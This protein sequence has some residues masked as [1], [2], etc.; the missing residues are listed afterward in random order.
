MRATRQQRKQRQ[1]ASHGASQG[2]AKAGDILIEA[3][4]RWNVP[5]WVLVGVK[6]LE[7]GT[8]TGGGQVSSAGALGPFQFEPGTAASAGVK[9][10][11]NFYESADGA[12]KLLAGYKQ[13]FGSWNAA[14]EAYN[15]GEGA[16]GGGYAYTEADAKKKLRE[17]GL[18]GLAGRATK[19][20]AFDP[21]SIFEEGL[22]YASPLYRLFKGEAPLPKFP[23]EDL[24]PGGLGS[25]GKSAIEPGS[26]GISFP[27][28]EAFFEL[29][30]S[31]QLWIRLAEI[32]GGAILAYLALKELTGQGISDLPGAKAAQMAA[33]L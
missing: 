27:N 16:V 10:P 18:G 22:K 29:L 11:N 32:I 25:G 30:R 21:G 2:S 14:L 17:Y 3:S 23:G 6:L 19:N 7:T 28:I 4:R 26:L 9:D 8:D 33:K 15:G 13:K 1:G 20:V 12:A 24:L 5:L 31:G